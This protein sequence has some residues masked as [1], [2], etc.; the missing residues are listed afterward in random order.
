[1]A[2]HPESGHF[3]EIAG[4]SARRALTDT[5]AQEGP[6]LFGTTA[7]DLQRSFGSYASPGKFGQLARRFFADFM[8]RAMRSFVDRELTN[9]LARGQ[10]PVIDRATAFNTALETHAWQAARV[11]E[12]FAGAWYSKHNWE[13]KGEI[14]REEAQRF[15]ARAFQK[16]R[17][18]IKHGT[19]P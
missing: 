8:S 13:S 2:T 1:V 19:E 18:E 11:I 9:I 15:V 12:T 4:L 14:S 3:G 17:S 7:E 5:V 6:S 10:G 16:L